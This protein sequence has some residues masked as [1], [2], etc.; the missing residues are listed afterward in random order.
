MDYRSST[1]VSRVAYVANRSVR[2]LFFVLVP[3]FAQDNAAEWFRAGARS[4]QERI[5]AG[6]IGEFGQSLR[7]NAAQPVANKMLGLAYL[8]QGRYDAAVEPFSQAA[9]L[10][11][12]DP[13]CWFFVGVAYYHL[14]FYAKAIAPLETALRLN[15]KDFRFHQYM[16]LVLEAL[17]RPEPA[18]LE[19]AEA[20]RLNGH[21]EQPSAEP[22]LDYG[23]LLYKQDRIAESEV[24]MRA[25][26][27]LNDSL[28]QP[29]FELGKILNR[30]GRPGEAIEQLEAALATGG[31]P[32]VDTARVN[33]LLGQICIQNGREQE[34]RRALARAEEL[35]Q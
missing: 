34:G 4:L 11:P 30:L 21:R 19:F 23:V 1:F 33:R 25:A 29:H 5:Y 13:E 32:A 3:L 14:N 10:A 28:W 22:H 6:A 20:V 12:K 9:R 26:I 8:M 2:L 27:K 7:I 24:Q 18:A 35:Q 15:S 16:G 31:A 17:G